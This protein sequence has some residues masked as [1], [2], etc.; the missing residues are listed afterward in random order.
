V[1]S[2]LVAVP[3]GGLILAT[4]TKGFNSS[5]DGSAGEWPSDWATPAGDDSGSGGTGNSD[6]LEVGQYS[7][8]LPEGWSIESG[9]GDQVVA[10]RGAN[11][12]LADTFTVDPD[13][14]RAIDL[15]GALVKHRQG[16]FT[17]SLPSPTDFSSGDVQRAGLTAAGKVRGKPATL[18]AQLWIDAVGD[19]LLVIETLVAKPGTKVAAEADGMVAEL[20]EGF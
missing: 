14:D 7:A 1:V 4:I 5:R 20:S 10:S 9:T 18:K 8:Q 17:G 11:R 6:T 13:A 15:I 12:L 19:A 16:A 2:L 3:I